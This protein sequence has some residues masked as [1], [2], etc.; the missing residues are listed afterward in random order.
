[1][2][3]AVRLTK[4][5]DW[6]LLDGASENCPNFTCTMNFAGPFAGMVSLDDVAMKCLALA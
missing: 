2:C 5:D 6:R 4:P 3:V 1:M